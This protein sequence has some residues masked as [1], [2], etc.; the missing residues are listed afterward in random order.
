MAS[1]T[2]I[3]EVVGLTA[4]TWA[5][6]VLLELMCILGAMNAYGSEGPGVRARAWAHQQEAAQERDQRSFRRSFKAGWLSGCLVGIGLTVLVIAWLL[7]GTSEIEEDSL[8]LFQLHF[9]AA[10]HKHKVK[11]EHA[12]TKETENEEF[13]YRTYAL[14]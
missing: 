2:H 9:D 1:L 10:A 8:Q 11:I 4:A 6:L 14:G 5:K 7:G 3:D 13:E 12:I